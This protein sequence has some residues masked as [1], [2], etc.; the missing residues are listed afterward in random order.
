MRQLKRLL[1]NRLVSPAETS[2]FISTSTWYK[3]LPEVQLVARDS[4]DCRV[5]IAL[6]SHTFAAEMPLS[7]DTVTCKRNR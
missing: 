5:Q 2:R 4:A 1:L 3:I 6:F 7:S